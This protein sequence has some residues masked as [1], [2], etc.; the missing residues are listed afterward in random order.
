M[1]LTIDTKSM[2][3]VESRVFRWFLKTL[4][5]AKTQIFAN[6]QGWYSDNR[7]VAAEADGGY[8]VAVTQKGKR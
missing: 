4:G 1:I 2:R 6:G 5:D 8:W 3:R 7:L